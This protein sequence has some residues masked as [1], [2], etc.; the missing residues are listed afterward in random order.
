M[1]TLHPLPGDAAP[2][3][4]WQGDNTPSLPHTVWSSIF[5]GQS[6]PEGCLPATAWAGSQGDTVPQRGAPPDLAG[7]RHRAAPTLVL[8]AGPR[9]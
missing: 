5:F 8:P 9:C 3:G 1:C 6:H 2:V 7:T 4:L